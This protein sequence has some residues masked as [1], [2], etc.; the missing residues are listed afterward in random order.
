MP[1]SDGHYGNR[2]SRMLR[3]CGPIFVIPVNRL[4]AKPENGRAINFN[5]LAYQ[6]TAMIKK[7]DGPA[8]C[9]L[10]GICTPEPPEKN[11][12]TKS[13]VALE[14][15]GQLSGLKKQ[16]SKEPTKNT[17]PP[18][19]KGVP[20]DI[21]KLRNFLNKKAGPDVDLLKNDSEDIKKN[22]AERERKASRA[23]SQF[24]V[25]RPVDIEHS[26]EFNS[27]GQKR[28]N[29]FGNG[30][31]PEDTR[32]RTHA[33]SDEKRKQ[34]ILRLNSRGQTRLNSG[35]SLSSQ[36]VRYCLDPASGEFVM[37]PQEN[38]IARKVPGGGFERTEVG[39]LIIEDVLE[40]LDENT[41]VIIEL[42]YH[43]TA[44]GADPVTKNSKPVLDEA[45]AP[46]MQGRSGAAA[47]FLTHD[48][49]S[50]IKG[51]SDR[52]GHYKPHSQHLLQAVEKLLEKGA[53]FEDSVANPDGIERKIDDKI[54]WEVEEQHGSMTVLKT[55]CQEKMDRIQRV[56]GPDQEAI[57]TEIKS[58]QKKIDAYENARKYLRDEGIRP[59]NRVSR[60]ITVDLLLNG[61]AH[62]FSVNDFLRSGGGNL[63]AKKAKED[64][65]LLL[66]SHPDVMVEP[67]RS[68]EQGKVAWVAPVPEPDRAGILL[69]LLGSEPQRISELKK[70]LL[71]EAL[72]LFE[73]DDHAGVVNCVR[74]NQEI[75]HAK[76]KEQAH[77][78]PVDL[79]KSKWFMEKISTPVAGKNGAIH[80][81]SL[82]YLDG[83]RDAGLDREARELI[84]GMIAAYKTRKSTMSSEEIF[85]NSGF[86]LR[87][88]EWLLESAK[89]KQ[90]WGEHAL[91]LS[92]SEDVYNKAEAMS[93]DSDDPH[94]SLLVE[95][96]LISSDSMISLGKLEHAELMMQRFEYHIKD[97]D[98]SLDKTAKISLKKSDIFTKLDKT[99]QAKDLC[100]IAMMQYL[101]VIYEQLGEPEATHAGMGRCLEQLAKLEATKKDNRPAE[102]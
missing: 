82:A 8:H 49:R 71:E 75:Y 9:E 102:H 50:K 59:T 16:Q 37:I 27:L 97:L 87:S 40:F 11:I 32:F 6:A 98:E 2:Q 17:A 4:D 23:A 57:K 70:S 99:D 35:R 39:P 1:R 86:F 21:E 64:F 24:F 45:G 90:H 67:P 62:R 92:I 41:D 18:G 22:L 76:I 14:N 84:N 5:V 33:Y 46:V 7:I 73:K 36:A 44:L 19:K 77:S 80:K 53:L 100:F 93:R 52:S 94:V 20:M 85:N 15:A 25:T 60:W 42:T 26:G 61:E 34:N 47:G 66:K 63:E 38:Y 3:H 68:E 13:A 69:A 58:L 96:L 28:A 29:Q 72:D 30:L 10:E 91:S 79:E 56:H 48:D 74:L 55:Q 88:N 54:Y 12:D 51:I 101:F 89:D 83:L 78:N 65:H 31:K 95:S 81:E 43:S